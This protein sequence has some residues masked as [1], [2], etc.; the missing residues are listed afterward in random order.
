MPATPGTEQTPIPASRAA[1]AATGD[2]GPQRCSGSEERL[3][4]LGRLPPWGSAEPA[5]APPGPAPRPQA[6]CNWMQPAHMFVGSREQGGPPPPTARWFPSGK[7][8]TELCV[9]SFFFFQICQS[10]QSL[11]RPLATKARGGRGP[12]A[13]VPHRRGCRGGNPSAH[14]WQCSRVCSS[15]SC[16]CAAGISMAFP[17]W[18][19]VCFIL[20]PS[21]TTSACQLQ[22]KGKEASCSPIRFEMQCVLDATPGGNGPCGITAQPCAPSASCSPPSLQLR[23]ARVPCG[24]GLR[25]PLELR[26]SWGLRWPVCGARPQHARASRALSLPSP[27]LPRHGRPAF[28]HDGLLWQTCLPEL[29]IRFVASFLPDCHSVKSRGRCSLSQPLPQPEVA[30]QLLSSPCGVYSETLGDGVSPLVK[31]ELPLAALTGACGLLW[32][33]CGMRV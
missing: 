14:T 28:P 20:C 29:A 30:R 17:H 16:P 23:G 4:A 26:A 21:L 27:P 22:V 31:E 1:R 12:G 6:P 9:T 25:K 3:S 11:P 15:G 19:N 2:P 7:R 5:A 8:G 13:R 24:C 18:R 32:R 33:S 10:D